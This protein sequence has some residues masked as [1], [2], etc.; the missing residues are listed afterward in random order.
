MF[1]VKPVCASLGDKSTLEMQMPRGSRTVGTVTRSSGALHKDP[2]DG[3]EPLR[4]R[5]SWIKT[6]DLS[7][8]RAHTH[9]VR[10]SDGPNRIET[11]HAAPQSLSTGWGKPRRRGARPK[12][13]TQAGPVTV[14]KQDGTV[15]IEPPRCYVSKSKGV[16]RVCHQPFKAGTV[17]YSPGPKLGI[18]HKAC[19]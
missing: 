14:V 10:S 13:Y 3:I 9:G 6:L 16:C 18:R 11:T 12:D 19:L 7:T 4:L 15:L 1:H 5:P 2:S 17:V 8:H